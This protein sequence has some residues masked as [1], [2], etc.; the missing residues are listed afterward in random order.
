MALSDKYGTQPVTVD[1]PRLPWHGVEIPAGFELSLSG[2]FDVRPGKEGEPA[3]LEA[4]AGCLWLVGLTTGTVGDWGRLLRFQDHDDRVK[5]LAIPAARLHE[6]PA[7]LARELA[8]LG[9]RIIPGKERR[10][11][12]YLA[13]FDTLERIQSAPRLGWMDRTDGALAFV[14][15][16]RVLS[17]AGNDKVVYQPE[18]YSPTA[19]TVHAAGS[20]EDWQTHIAAAVAGSDVL[21]FALCAGL[22]PPWLKLADSDSFIVHLWGT[23]SRGKTTLAQIA[24]SAWGCAVDPAESASL[25]MIRRW[26][27]TG[28]GLEG[29]AESH[30]DL[31]L[32]LDELGAGNAKD[33]APLVY[34]L[35]G[36]QGK[37]AMTASRELRAPRAWRTIAI[38]TGELSLEAKLSEG[39]K[40]PKGG[41]LHRALDIEVNDIAAHMPEEQRAG[42]VSGIK[43]DCAKYYGNAGASVL[44]AIM[45]EYP[46]I[47]DARNAARD[48]LDDAVKRLQQPH[49]A[50]EQVRALRRFALIAW[51]GVFAARHGVLPIDPK[52]IWQAVAAIAG[53]WGSNTSGTDQDRLIDAV[54]AFILK[55]GGRFQS[56]N[57]SSFDVPNRAGFHDTQ[58]G[59]WL[60]TKEALQE[61]APGNDVVTIARALKD[62]GHLF[63]SDTNL[64]SKVQTP[65]GRVRLY[66][67]KDSIFDDSTGQAPKTLGQLGQLGQT[68]PPC[69]LQP[70]LNEQ[71]PLGQLGHD[72]QSALVPYLEKT[73]RAGDNPHSDSPRPSALDALAKNS[74][75]QEKPDDEVHF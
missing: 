42:Y 68:P 72:E 45:A 27:T 49:H 47:Q 39:G 33:Y 28:N 70:A 7:I 61:A 8:T 57:G 43:R 53:Q 62:A 5:E 48:A 58:A 4:I 55:H 17:A 41:L 54:R 1:I 21:L 71:T 6:D 22:A 40:P 30:S 69:G 13:S 26:N 23:T 51:A 19:S 20:L 46:S 2:V 11:V 64:N 36:G 32:C 25:S 73:T 18:R 63:T 24:A 65:A 3:K 60:F 12:A 14:F 31:A 52:R 50:P 16:D 29:M 59:R 37:T 15:P 35:A 9:L 67:V 75:S 34:Q 38:S 66:S 74:T 44:A 56:V 10:L